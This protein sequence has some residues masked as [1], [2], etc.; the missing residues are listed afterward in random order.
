MGQKTGT[1]NIE[2]K[3]IRKAI[4]KAL[5]M[6]YLKTQQRKQFILSPEF[7][8]SLCRKIKTVSR[9][10][11]KAYTA[12]NYNINSNKHSEPAMAMANQAKTWLDK[13]RHAT[14]T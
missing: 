2:K 1:S 14:E 4:Q 5:V 7:T 3:V 10:M 11:L 8:E 9:R 12:L 13:F 6:E